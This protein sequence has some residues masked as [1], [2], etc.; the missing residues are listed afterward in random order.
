LAKKFGKHHAID[1]DMKF[2]EGN[3]LSVTIQLQTGSSTTKFSAK[4]YRK[5]KIN[6]NIKRELT[7]TQ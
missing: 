3:S 6:N 7:I 5:E 4:I 2:C 1:I